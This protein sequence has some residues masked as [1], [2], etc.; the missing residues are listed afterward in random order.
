ME[1]P[2]PAARS[3]WP[4]GLAV[5]GFVLLGAAL[6]MG[7]SSGFGTAPRWVGAASTGVAL[8]SLACHVAAVG[9]SL[10]AWR[11]RGGV[12]GVA[13]FYGALALSAGAWWAWERAAV[14]RRFRDTPGLLATEFTDGGI[15]VRDGRGV[16]HVPF[17]GCPG[18][19]GA[20]GVR[21][22]YG[23]VEVLNAA[24]EPTMRLQVD[25]RRAQ[26]LRR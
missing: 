25:A 3:D 19:R 23:V 14:A 22:Q 13:L 5:A 20:T 1:P 15:D 24:G 21:S 10:A 9:A 4:A 6:W 8:V 12:P 11:T 16:W 2:S 7:L 26:C 18:A 17:A